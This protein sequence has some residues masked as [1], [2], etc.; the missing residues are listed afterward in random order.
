M[1]TIPGIALPPDT[2]VQEKNA[3]IELTVGQE[4]FTVNAA[5]MRAASEHFAKMFSG[6]YA[7]GT[8]A[9]LQE[10][11]ADLFK[12]V[13]EICYGRS[14]SLE[15]EDY[16]ETLILLQKYWIPMDLHSLI[17]QVEVPPDFF[18]RYLFYLDCLYPT[19][20]NQETI[21][22]IAAQ[23]GPDTDISTLDD[24]FQTE[25]RE[26]P[27]FRYYGEGLTRDLVLELEQLARAHQSDPVKH[28]VVRNAQQVYRKIP[29]EQI[30]TARC[31]AEAFLKIRDWIYYLTG[32]PE[33]IRRVVN[34]D[35]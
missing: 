1:Y 22:V 30:F 23:V 33:K 32:H 29:L 18:L 7:E 34:S 14:V 35:L 13:I 21:D 9:T 6:C 31:M 3:S 16:F 26:S 10:G 5:V 2:I 11:R 20:F 12:C 4:H 17:E 24:T 19:G 25:L 27:R 28:Y 15:L 8:S